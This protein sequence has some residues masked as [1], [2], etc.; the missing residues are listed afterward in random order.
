MAVIEKGDFD[1]SIIDG[2]CVHR[3]VVI[4]ENIQ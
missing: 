1:V 2:N 3:P 4:T